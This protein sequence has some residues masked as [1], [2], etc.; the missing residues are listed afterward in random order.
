M[1]TRLFDVRRFMRFLWRRDADQGDLMA[2]AAQDLEAH[3][4]EAKCL[5]DI[6]N[7]PRRVQHQTG[8]GRGMVVGQAPVHLSIEVADRILTIDDDRTVWLRSQTGARDV[9][10]VGDVADDLFDDVFQGDDAEQAAVFIDDER[11]MFVTRAECM[12][13]IE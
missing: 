8:D 2:L 12:K 1:L 11:E 13:L 3:A 6:R 5:S 7:A 10:F 4:V 9:E